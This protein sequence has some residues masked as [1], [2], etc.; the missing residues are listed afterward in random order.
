MT[1]NSTDIK[2]LSTTIATAIESGRIGRP[3]FVR[4]M[5]RVDADP[6]LYVAAALEVVSG[7]F[8]AEPVASHR[9]GGSDLQATMFARWP[10]GQSAVLIAAP[11]GRASAPDLDVAVIGA[12]G[13]AYHHA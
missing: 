1:N 5:E 10:D 11:A 9:P 8:G 13:A 2:L 7:W 6:E 12:R 3:M 4:W